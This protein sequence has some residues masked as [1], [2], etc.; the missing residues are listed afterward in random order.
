MTIPPKPADA[1]PQLIA[2]IRDRWSPVA[3]DPMRAVSDRQ[4][5]IIFDAAR[6]APSSFNEQPWRYLCARRGD[7]QREALDAALFDGNAWARRAPVLLCSLMKSTFTRNGKQNRVAA[8]DVGLATMSLVIQAGALG[9]ITHQMG[10]FDRE[11]VRTAFAVPE[12]FA[13]VA[14]VAVGWHDPDVQDPVLRA[15]EAGK[16]R[17]RRPLEELVFGRRFGEVLELEEE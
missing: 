1:H 7:A 9:M 5:R 12:D 3:F 2:P 13:P 17:T 10:G 6:W 11:A 4:L 14:M 15:K 8:H 16:V